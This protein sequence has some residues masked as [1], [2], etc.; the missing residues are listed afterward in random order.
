MTTPWYIAIV[1]AVIIVLAL[2][3]Y[4]GRLLWQVKAQREKIAKQKAKAQA[5]LSKKREE[6][7]AKLGDSINLLARAMKEKQCEYS[8]GC[9]RV[10]VL[11]SQYAFETE[12]E[13]QSEFQG[14]FK[15]Y[16]EVKDMPTH[17]ARK[18]YSKKE[19]FKMD[20]Q[21]WKAEE[22][23]E[24]EILIDCDKLISEFYPL[25]GQENVVFS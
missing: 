5:E 8:E 17:D 23:L 9:L 15:M 25:P 14:V 12:R 4:A 2:A 24:N 3:F 11:L 13:L 10:W 6:R 20:S 7:N 19:I 18:K 16:D 22:R 21:R 1:V